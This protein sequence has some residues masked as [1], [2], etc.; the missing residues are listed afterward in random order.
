LELVR[1]GVWWRA[2]V[3]VTETVSAVLKA[4]GRSRYGQSAQQ[5]AADD[6]RG[7]GVQKG[8]V[9]VVRAGCRKK[10]SW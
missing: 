4:R 6:I 1:C 2:V 10:S 8:D 3:L 5:P 9:V 7:A